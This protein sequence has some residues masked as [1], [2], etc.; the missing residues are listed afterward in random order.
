[1]SKSQDDLEN[2]TESVRL[3]DLT[4]PSKSVPEKVDNGEAEQ[5][6]EITADV[7]SE[8]EEIVPLYPFFAGFGVAWFIALTIAYFHLNE[9]TVGCG[10]GG[11]CAQIYKSVLSI[12]FGLPLGLLGAVVYALPLLVLGGISYSRS[13]LK[14]NQNDGHWNMVLSVFGLCFYAGTCLVAGMEIYLIYA[15]V[16]LGS[17]CLFCSSL[18][19]VVLGCFGLMLYYDARFRFGVILTPIPKV[20]YVALGFLI[21][22]FVISP[23][24]AYVP[25]FSAEAQRRMEMAKMRA[26]GLDDGYEK[27]YEV[28]P[29]GVREEKELVV[30]DVDVEKTE[31][32]LFLEENDAYVIIDPS[33]EPMFKGDRKAIAIKKAKKYTN[34][35]YDFK[36]YVK[37]RGL[38]DPMAPLRL[39]VV[40]NYSCHACAVME[41]VVVP[42]IMGLVSEGQLYLEYRIFQIDSMPFSDLAAKVSVAASLQGV[43]VWKRVHHELFAGQKEWLTN[44]DVVQVI[45]HVVDAKKLTK[46]MTQW[47]EL[48]SLLGAETKYLKDKMRISA[49]PT[50]LLYKRGDR[51]PIRRFRSVSNG[52]ILDEILRKTLRNR[53]KGDKS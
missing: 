46:A 42:E 16:V 11:G 24:G 4:L 2:N 26:E 5:R 27:P 53:A 49:T 47:D 10:D 19:G 28:E 30:V 25:E 52:K 7:D 23:R 38:G 44:G 9:I 3:G 8:E 18:A 13:R 43:E 37:A 12:A 51:E 22:A 34:D 33:S 14:E 17:F 6:Q 15:Q 29:A 1:M 45:R 40:V 20:I 50:L 35:T 36:D 48:E 41:M 32:E 39:V 31:M 21:V